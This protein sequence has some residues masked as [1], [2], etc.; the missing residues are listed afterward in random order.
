MWEH[1]QRQAGNIPIVIAV[2]ALLVVIGVLPVVLHL[3]GSLTVGSLAKWVSTVGT[4]GALAALLFAARECRAGQDERLAN[5]ADQAR[6]MV[7]EHIERHDDPL[8]EDDIG[9]PNFF[10]SAPVFKLGD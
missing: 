3:Q 6:L 7:V 5:E 8:A 1:W 2:L 10:S 9:V 4:L